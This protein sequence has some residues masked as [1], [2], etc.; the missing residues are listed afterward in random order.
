MRLP[1]SFLTVRSV[2]EQGQCI[3]MKIST[4]T[5]VVHVQ[6]LA[7][8]KPRISVR[9]AISVSVP[10][11]RY[12]M[13]MSGIT[14]SLAGK[15]RINAMRI[16]PSSPMR[17]AKGSRKSAP[18]RRSVTSPTVTFARIQITRPAG[19]ATAAERAS[20][21]RVRSK[22]ERTRTFPTCGL[23]KG[24]SSSVNAEG[25]PRNRVAERSLVSTRVAKIPSRINAVRISADTA[26]CAKP[27]MPTTKNIPMIA[28]SAGK[29]PL[30]GTKLL[31]RIAN[32]RSRGESM[33]RQPTIPAALQ[34]KPMH[35]GG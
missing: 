3:R 16:T 33:M 28:I 22:I 14:I 17:R 12:A 5:A 1:V 9:L 18:M 21:K 35:M 8:S 24:G 11:E 2:V 25:T 30:Q 32:S 19:A 13:R 31:V 10:S 6:P 7:T 20:T 29:R 15:P 27:P 23:R 34:P 4:Q 26:V